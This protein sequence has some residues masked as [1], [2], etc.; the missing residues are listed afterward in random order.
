MSYC[1][2]NQILFYNMDEYEQTKVLR[3]VAN[4]LR[5]M[6]KLPEYPVIY[7]P[8]D[9][10]YII[11]N[12]PADSIY[13]QKYNLN[14]NADDISIIL[15]EKYGNLLKSLPVSLVTINRSILFY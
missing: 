2:E 14:R 15:N 6:V 9:A 10:S 8:L 11:N 1:E 7:D 12:L 5:R 13:Y 3:T 4:E